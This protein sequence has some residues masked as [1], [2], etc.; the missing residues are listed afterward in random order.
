MVFETTHGCCKAR[1][2]S[3][4]WEYPREHVY[5]K[6]RVIEVEIIEVS[7]VNAHK[8]LT[9]INQMNQQHMHILCRARTILIGI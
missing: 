8:Y 6:W 3:S 1:A 2:N 9:T 5:G 4:S 7:K